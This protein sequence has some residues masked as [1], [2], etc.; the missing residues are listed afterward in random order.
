MIDFDDLQDKAVLITGAADG[1]GL[2]LA[3]AF[4][5]AGA[6]VCLSDIAAEKVEQQAKRLA[7]TCAVCDVT[8]PASAEATV[9]QTWQQIGPIDL[10]CSNA[11]VIA[12]G[13]LLEASSEDIAFQFDVNVWGN[14]NTCRPYVR[15]LREAR[16]PGHVLLTGSE[17]SLSY[18]GYLRSVPT[19]IYNMTKHCV[20][21]MGDILRSEL[22]GDGIGVS[23]LCPGPVESG[24]GANSARFRPERYGTASA[25]LDPLGDGSLDPA[26]VDRIVALYRPA[27]EAAQIAIEGLRRGLFVIPTHA[28]LKDDATERFREIE[29]G[30][31]LLD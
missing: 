14:L 26:A 20:L 19:A 11:G 4:S 24:L 13:P 23:V 6:R 5:T 10:L 16:R 29:R 22:A 25:G 31:E 15:K 9:E 17:H 18:P 2:A 12:P 21:A 8:D 28:H 27:S 7:A 3:E 30:F 1:I